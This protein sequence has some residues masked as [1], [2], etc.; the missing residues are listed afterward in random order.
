VKN[1]RI[2]IITKYFPPEN[3]V[4]TL[5]PYSWARYW[6]EAGHEVEVLTTVKDR[7]RPENTEM[8]NT[9][10]TVHEVDFPPIYQ[11]LK[12]LYKRFVKA[13]PQSLSE[14]ALGS[15]GSAGGAGRPGLLKRVAAQA[16]DWRLR[17]GVM[18]AIRMPDNFDFWVGQG[19][20][21]AQTRGPWDLVVS[22]HAPYATHLIAEKLKR[23]KLART[24][25]ADFRDLWTDNHIYKGLFPFTVAEQYLEKRA[26]T[27]ADA[28]TTV[29]EPLAQ[30]LAS[31]YGS[32]KVF[33]VENGYDADSLGQLPPAPAFP[34][35][36]KKRIIHTGTIYRGKQ[37]PSLFFEAVADLA[38]QPAGKEL[39]DRL[40]VLFVGSNPDVL[41]E[42]V[43]QYGVK[44][45]VKL[46][47]F[48][49]RTEVLRMQ[50]DAD[51]LLFLEFDR[52]KTAGILTGKL[53]EYLSSGT[54]VWG[55]GVHASSSPGRLIQQAGGGIL[56][57]ENQE[58]LRQELQ[59]FL[60][61]E[62]KRQV[63]LHK[64]VLERYERKALASK[65]LGILPKG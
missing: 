7:S 34:A 40:E 58:H 49:P 26:M 60:Q 14:P 20:R 46:G 38:R 65:F 3:S 6:A 2:L 43:R 47:S 48:L 25:V 41:Q 32:E 18:L 10:F 28:I 42:A 35:D 17:R 51:A 1:M 30:I 37:D 39:L 33:V 29:S 62:V 24:W 31:K 45:W 55:V 59:R 27:S 63:S 9:G 21:W 54:Q 52:G 11:R 53:F 15:G 61:E 23:E 36:G 12:G 16:N 19:L 5:R 44:E 56:F 50:R 4:A 13:N 57:G 8:P 22:T 64:E